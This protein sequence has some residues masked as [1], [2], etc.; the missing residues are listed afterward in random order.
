MSIHAAPKS[1]IGNHHLHRYYTGS[2]PRAGT[3]PSVLTRNEILRSISLYY[4][5]GTFTSSVYIY[6]QNPH[7]FGTEYTKA[8]TD[9]PMLFSAFKYNVAFWPQ[10]LVAKVGNLVYYRSKFILFGNVSLQLTKHSS[11]DHDFGGHFSG[12]DNPPA[13]LH[14]LREIGA[15]WN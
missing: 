12:V 11:Q 14:D 13:L 4:L 2:D 8:R 5:T 3:T 15:Y 7:G 9:A 6:Y 1:T 10:K